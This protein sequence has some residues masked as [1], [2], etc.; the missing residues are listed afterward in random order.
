M[1]SHYGRKFDEVLR[2]LRRECTLRT[3]VRVVTKDLGSMKL[4]GCCLAYL[5]CDGTIERFVIKVDKSMTIEAA[6]ETLL[7]E[8]AHAMDKEAN[9]I[10][11]EP[12]RN[13]WGECYA[14]VWRVYVNRTPEA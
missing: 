4:C 14:R 7:H 10:P 1:A 5:R 8:W 13:S 6:I 12:H 2:D 11:L 9:G 3:P